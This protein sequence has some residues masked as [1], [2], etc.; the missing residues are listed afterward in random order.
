MSKAD[1]AGMVGKRVEIVELCHRKAVQAHRPRLEPQARHLPEQSARE[2]RAAQ[3]LRA[4]VARVLR[5]Q[6]VP[7]LLVELTE[8]APA[9]PTER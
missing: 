3:G 6:V 5:E 4:A 7:V 1:L 9:V 2:L 8:S